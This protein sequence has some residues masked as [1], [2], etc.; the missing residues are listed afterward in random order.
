MVSS[1]SSTI[2]VPKH[3]ILEESEYNKLT[4]YAA[5]TLY[6][7]LEPTTNWTFGGTFPVILGGSSIG[8]FPITLT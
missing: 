1:G 2:N 8:E 7:V 3:V 6:F 4:E 5:N